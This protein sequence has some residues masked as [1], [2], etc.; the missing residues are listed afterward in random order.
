M[1]EFITLFDREKPIIGMIHVRALP[2]T[3]GWDGDHAR[4]IAQAIDEARVL[5]DV[6]FDGLIVENMHD[7]PYL[8]RRVGPEITAMM[9]TV[10][11]GIRTAVDVPLG[12]Q[13][14]AGANREAIAVAQAS[15]ARFIRAEGFAYASVA[16]EGLL[17]E[18]DAG[19]LLRYRR[20][21][22]AMDIAILTDV[23]K[24]HSSHAITSDVS[25]ATTIETSEF[26]GADGL[27][28]TGAATG[29]AAAMDDLT[30]SVAAA[31]GPVLVGSGITSETIAE[32]LGIVDGVIVGS[33]I[34]VD[35]HWAAPVDR[36]RA[37][38]VVEAGRRV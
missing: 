21:I 24:K 27:I 28:V 16:D 10:V 2:G 5:A 38:A 7:V 25:L 22:D 35:G 12:V 18:A 3:P 23:K 1:P 11:G 17:D 4:V 30:A 33:D 31:T 19:P 14:L 20:A 32:V 8:R 36:D 37:A 29:Q 26:M 13:I 9:T 6:G 15:G 34:K